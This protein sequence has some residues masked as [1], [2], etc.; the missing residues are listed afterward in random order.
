MK[1]IALILLVA[2]S[3]GVS[4]QCSAPTGLS[5]TGIT[6]TAATAK[7]SPVT[8]ASS[9]NV[10]YKPA[11]YS[12]WINI[13]NATTSLQWSLYGMT[14]STFYEWRVSANCSSGASSYSQTSFTTLA[15]GS[16]TAPVGLFASN[17]AS[18]TATL[19]WSPVNGALVYTVVYKPTSSLIWITAT[20]GTYGTSVNLYSLS[21]NTTYDFKVYTNC[22]LTE[23]SGYSVTA[24]FTTSGSSA[25]TTSACPGPNDVSSNGTIGGAAAISLNT[26]VKGTVAPKYDIDHYQFTISTYGT[27][28]VW[29]TTLPA[30]YDLAVLN[31]SGAQIGIS[32]NKGSRS[33]SVSLMANPGTYYAKVYPKGT[34][35]NAT[36]CYTLK[37]QTITAT[38]VT[39]TA[40]AVTATAG[41]VGVDPNLT[42]NL[43]PNPAGHQLN[44]WVEGVDRRSDI[45]VYNLMGKLV[46]RQGIGNTLTQ[47][48][49]SK[50]P[51]GI[52]LL[53]VNNGKETMAAKFVKQ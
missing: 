31:S 5:T 1:L 46:M 48:N 38:R 3:Y 28:T 44:V 27:F 23:S 34:A 17:I 39:T 42:I 15:M 43:Y 21:A 16:C 6:A 19:N 18:T 35:N 14:P 10:D 12:F 45:K 33:E 51:A 50:L 9:Y 13:A 2:T 40:T 30:N 4:A 52:Y 41:E 49:I 36:S 11:G 53:K 26:D 47:L 7:W 32:Q 37:V 20:S 22:S 24:Q 29:L 8:G 25:P